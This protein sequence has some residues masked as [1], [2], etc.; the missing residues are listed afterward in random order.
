M[1]SLE[2]ADAL[3]DS[4]LEVFLATTAK[5]VPDKDLLY[6]YTDFYGL[7]GIVE[8]HSLWATYSRTLNDSTEQ[9]YGEKV[10]C[11]ILQETV[12]EE[13]RERIAAG[14]KEWPD[15]Y[16]PFVACFC[17]DPNLLSM[18][19]SY[20]FRGGG[21][22]LGFDSSELRK[23]VM[24][25]S[26]MRTYQQK[27]NYLLKIVYGLPDDSLRGSLQQLAKRIE[28]DPA[29]SLGFSIARILASKIKHEA[30]REE[31]EWRIIVHDPVF[32]EM[33]FR[34]GHNNIIPYVDL[35]RHSDSGGPLLP[36]RKVVC[37]PTLRNDDELR[38]T[39]KWMLAKHGYGRAEIESCEI[40]YRL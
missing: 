1:T 2:D 26:S 35:R 17:T 34:Q 33:K 40:P 37:G 8:S 7:K 10:V 4:I 19:R 27:F 39:V 13:L 36:L 3:D 5:D 38:E 14:M 28:Q 23:V 11:K 16:R 18:W 20:A 12:N 32:E 6:H 9:R 22:C 15:R 31:N 25:R 21:Y 24:E 30:F 29:R